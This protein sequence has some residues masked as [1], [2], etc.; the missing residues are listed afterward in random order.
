MSMGIN[1]GPLACLKP[2]FCNGYGRINKY[3]AII[4][5]CIWRREPK[6][7]T[8]STMATCEPKEITMSTIATC[9]PE[10][11]APVKCVARY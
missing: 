1:N 2:G 5:A 4:H 9:E 6:E 11:S 7:I 10:T 8:M 3:V